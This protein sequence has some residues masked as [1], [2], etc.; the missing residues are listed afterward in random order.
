MAGTET[1]LSP[2]QPAGK[3]FFAFA[4]PKSG[5][6]PILKRWSADSGEPLPDIELSPGFNLANA[7]AD[8][9]LVLAAKPVGADAA[10]IQNYLWSIYS[11]SN[12]DRVAEVKMFPSTA[13][14]LIWRSNLIYVSPRYA[15]QVNGALR[16]E[17]LELRALNVKS[18]TEV[19]KSPIRDTSYRGPTP[20][21]P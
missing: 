2:P 6:P 1:L 5:E 13:P 15:R 9:T 4:A 10:G 12:G 16:E 7:S 14:F 8:G 17:P 3:F 21:A 19:W 18:G 20:P 11:L